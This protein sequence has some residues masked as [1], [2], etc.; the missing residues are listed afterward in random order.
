[1][2]KIL[3]ASTALTAMAAADFAAADI[4]NMAFSGY[5]RFGLKYDGGAEGD[6]KETFLTSRFRLNIDAN[7]ETDGGV[8]FSARVRL[9]A[10]AN[11]DGT[12]NQGNGFSGGV[13]QNT[14]TVS[15]TTD[16]NGAQLS[17]ARFTTQYEGLRVD[18]GNIS[19]VI[20]NL[21]NYYGN[22]PGLTAFT[23]QYAAVDFAL[24][25]FSS[26]SAGVNGIF[27]QY[28]FGDFAVS[29]S[30][31]P[32]ETGAGEQWGV[33]GAWANDAYAVALF[34]SQNEPEGTGGL[35][36]T[37]IYGATAA[38]TFGAFNGTLLVGKEDADNDDGAFDT[39]W[40]LSAAYEL[41]TATDLIFSYA[42]G[43]GDDDTQAFGL[44]VVQDLGG[45]VALK[46]GVASVKPGGDSS[47]TVADVG[48]IFNF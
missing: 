14:N 9:Q 36:E 12:A 7:A 42:D 41:G 24:D 17:G 6:D 33:S 20:D 27:A 23:G 19:G 13:D 29:A 39:F 38:A 22:E 44:G 5:G 47:D 2:K 34:Y 18:V 26:T 37:K 45:G 43:S 28:A 30:Y 1:M 8:A 25:S 3:F 46:G 35:G 21:P 31:S 40:G 32:E 15:G 48:V 11:Q 10:D 16:R 4:A